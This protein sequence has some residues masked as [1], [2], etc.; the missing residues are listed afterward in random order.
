[1]AL[2]LVSD[3]VEFGGFVDFFLLWGISGHRNDTSRREG[4]KVRRGVGY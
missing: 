2:D 4:D 1:M 3:S